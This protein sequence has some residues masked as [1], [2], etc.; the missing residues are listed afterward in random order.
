M[1][2]LGVKRERRPISW[3]WACS[4]RLIYG[5]GAITAGNL[6]SLGVLKD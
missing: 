4:R 6:G 2:L 1:A 5:D 3:P